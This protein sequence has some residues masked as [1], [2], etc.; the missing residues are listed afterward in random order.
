[1]NRIPRGAALTGNE[2]ATPQAMLP[3]PSRVLARWTSRKSIERSR[4][5]ETN[6]VRID[7]PCVRMRMT[8]P[9]IRNDGRSVKN[10][11]PKGSSPTRGPNNRQPPAGSPNQG[12]A[13]TL[14]K[15]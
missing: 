2:P 14:S 10:A 4:R 7:A 15:S 3:S 6:C 11:A 5:H 13:R 9:R 1:M 8:S 12:A